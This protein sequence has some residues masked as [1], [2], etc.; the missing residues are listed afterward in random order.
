MVAG[1][2]T[3]CLW[4]WRSTVRRERR[5]QRRSPPGCF[6]YCVLAVA[7]TTGKGLFEIHDFKNTEDFHL[8]WPLVWSPDGSRLAF[9]VRWFPIDAIFM[10]DSDGGNLA[11]ITDGESAS[12]LDSYIIGSW[13]D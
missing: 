9:S 1:R 13:V 12:D 4:L 3:P 8:I 10:V 5:R 11:R 2:L 6:S 7:D